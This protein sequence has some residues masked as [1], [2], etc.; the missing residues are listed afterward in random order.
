VLGIETQGRLEL[1]KHAVPGI[2][3]VECHEIA[4]CLSGLINQNK[5]GTEAY[6][7]R[8][9]VSPEARWSV[10]IVKSWV[11]ESSRTRRRPL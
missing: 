6:S 11:V 4:A 10:V 7:L 9:D 3:R 8:A 5:K 1:L 2:S